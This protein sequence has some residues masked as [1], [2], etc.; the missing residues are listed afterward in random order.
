MVQSGLML[1]RQGMVS[2]LRFINK[3]VLAATVQDVTPAKVELDLSFFPM[4]DCSCPTEGVCRH[5]IAVFFAAY[6]TAR[7]VAEWV[8]EWREPV[9]ETAQITKWGV[10]K[11]KDLVKA[12]NT[13]PADYNHWVQSFAES[14]DSLLREK[15][16]M[17]PYVI[18]ELFQIYR[19]R[20]KASAPLE[21]KWRM[22]YELIANVLSF[23]KLATLSEE[24]G[25]TEE[26][27]KRTYLHL[28]H[29]LT[30]D[31]E[32]LLAKMGHQALPFA[33]DAHLEQFKDD[34]FGLLTCATSLSYE[35]TSLYQLLWTDF[36][37]KNAWRTAELTRIE[38]E[39]R[40]LHEQ[41]NPL[42][43][44][45]AAI[46]LRM[47]TDADEQALKLLEEIED[48][49]VT[50]YMLFWIDLLTQQ[51]AWKRVGPMI[52]LFLQKV[53]GYLLALENYYACTSFTRLAIKAIAPYC[54]EMGRADLYE[55]ALG[56]MLPYS[57][58]EYEYLLFQRG[59]YDRWSE[60]YAFIGVDFSDLPKD[61][62]K[63]IEKAQPE[64][65]FGLL[66]QSAQRAI[67][68]K[69]RQSYRTAVR[70][71]KKLRTLYKKAKRL[72]DWQFFFDHLID[73]TKRLRAFHEECRRSKLLEE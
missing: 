67:E 12:N 61:R 21:Q 55:R 56:Q 71:L 43:L 20:I 47:L 26:A 53:K 30:D 19:R 73:K 51:N 45:I 52:E 54:G 50:P 15:A 72:D 22:L 17:S 24:L 41:A 9:R 14:F 7:S 6:A 25:H 70:Y 58:S 28:F 57:F 32:Q 31:T 62:V 13:L 2:H 48:A 60:L 29:Q 44:L 49:V 27:V 65:L 38:Q 69:N 10:Q 37:R 39:L 8:E 3:D 68:L 46:H 23:Q 35:R 4:S 42:P 63:I 18:A 5:Q 36:F 16:N 59:Q 33:F 66:H 40:R 1:Y 64:V 11:A 34:A